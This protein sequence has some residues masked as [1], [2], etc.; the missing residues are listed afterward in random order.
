MD[1]ASTFI[2]IFSLGLFLVSPLIFLLS[3]L[4][5]IPIALIGLVFTGII[6]SIAV[7]ATTIAFMKHADIQQ[8]EKYIEKLD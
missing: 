7:Q 4:L 5:S 2:Q 6:V 8:I 3:K 1:F